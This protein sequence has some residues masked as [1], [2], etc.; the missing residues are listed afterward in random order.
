MLTDKRY[1]VYINFTYGDDDFESNWI[2]CYPDIE[3]FV[4]KPFSGEMFTR[5]EWGE[6]TFRNMPNLSGDAYELYDT[7]YGILTDDITR[8][9]RIKVTVPDGFIDPNDTDEIQ[10][11]FGAN[12]CD[13]DHDKKIVKVKPAILDQYT[14]V[15]EN[16]ETEVDVIGKTDAQKARWRLPSDYLTDYPSGIN[17]SH[18]IPLE[19]LASELTEAKDVV[20][21]SGTSVLN[22]LFSQSAIKYNIS[23]NISISAALTITGG[24]NMKFYVYVY[25]GADVLRSTNLLDTITASGNLSTL[26]TLDLVVEQGDYII[27]TCEAS[28]AGDVIHYSRADISATATGVPY[29]TTDLNIRVRDTYFSSLSVWVETNGLWGRAEPRESDMVALT[30]YFETSGEPK[31]SLFEN[32]SRAPISI[33]NDISVNNENGYDNLSISGLY[34]TD[35]KTVLGQYGYEVSSVTIYKGNTFY[36]SLFGAK[37]RKVYCTATFTRFEAWVKVGETPV[38]TGWT[39]SE[40][41]NSNG[42][43]LWYKKPYDGAYADDWTLG[44]LDTSGGKIDG[45]DWHEKITSTINYPDSDDNITVQSRSLYEVIKTVYNGTHPSLVNADVKSVFFWNDADE[46][47]TVAA[48]INYATE[49]DQKLNNIA[50]VHTYQFKEAD[51][52]SEDAKLEISLKETLTDLKALFNNQIYWFVDENLDLHIEHLKYIDETKTTLDL[53]EGTPYTSNTKLLS[54]LQRWNYQKEKMYSRIEVGCINSGY[55]DFTDNLITFDK[56]VSNKRNEDIRNEISTKIFSTD[57]KYC[58]LNPTDLDNGLLLVNHDA[59][60]NS[61]NALVPIEGI[62][63]E[64]GNLAL[65]NLLKDYRYEGTFTEGRINGESLEF[66]VTSRTKSGIEFTI[67][68]IYDYD[69]FKNIVG[70]GMIQS[71][72]HDF[73]RESTTITLLHRFGSDAE[74]DVF[75]LMVSMVGDF[76]GATDIRYDFEEG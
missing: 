20:T 34:L 15:L 76:E 41:I 67:K 22:A 24:E 58:V 1:K 65:S 59:D 40:Y 28:Y 74:T 38:G 25:S 55:K 47:L 36:I 46:N 64:N 45:M 11:Y 9:I 44:A 27:I 13:F 70:V 48:G 73:D 37:R 19:V 75:M 6:V 16:W 52:E 31:D 60:Y 4:K 32:N 17:E 72:K 29:T 69:F 3:P 61:I 51:E 71:L 63:F 10:G 66:P 49:L 42:L 56:I 62:E 39:D 68:G 43:Q 33:R 26:Y 53:T 18:A 7:I 57:L 50:C 35:L 30:E 12:D 5:Y 2:Q 54:E 23:L 8:E 21:L 14:D